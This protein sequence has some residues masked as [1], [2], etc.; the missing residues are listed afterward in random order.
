MKPPVALSL[1]G[2]FDTVVT[3]RIGSCGECLRA[4][5]CSDDSVRDQ[6]SSHWYA[7]ECRATQGRRWGRGLSQ[8]AA[9]ITTSTI[10]HRR[11]HH[12]HRRPA[13][14]TTASRGAALPGRP[15]WR[16]CMNAPVL[17][18]LGF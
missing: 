8:P 17:L 9:V 10:V 6:A 13:V 1:D 11:Y 4:D 14:R 5:G 2:Y 15:D 18:S 3:V 16:E 12:R 7:C